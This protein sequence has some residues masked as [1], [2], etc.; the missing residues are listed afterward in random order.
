[1][2]EAQEN[3]RFQFTLFGLL[4]L[5]GTVAVVC[6][7]LCSAYRWFGPETTDVLL[8]LTT[9]AWPTI[10][11]IGFARVPKHR[12]RAT[13]AAMLTI[14]LLAA[15]TASLEVWAYWRALAASAVFVTVIWL[16]QLVVIWII[17][18]DIRD[19]EPR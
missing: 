2:L 19:W 14:S 10:V 3:C 9:L 7:L 15:T 13:V 16:P 18:L 8:A 12:H 5:T 4:W 6:W 1:M 11:G 17:C